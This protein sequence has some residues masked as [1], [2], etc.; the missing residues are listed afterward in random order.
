VNSNNTHK[1]DIVDSLRRLTYPARKRVIV[2]HVK[3]HDN[4][5]P[6]LLNLLDLIED[7]E[8]LLPLEVINALDS[9]RKW[10][11]LRRQTF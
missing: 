8:Y 2:D 4:A 11:R 10:A 9:A 1:F 7:V 3:K 5:P 6:E